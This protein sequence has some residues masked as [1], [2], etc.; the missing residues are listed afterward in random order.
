[1]QHT[2]SSVGPSFL[3]LLALLA[4]A[5]PSRAAAPPAG[6]AWLDRQVA[7]LGADDFDER[8]GAS[9]TLQRA[10]SAAVPALKRGSKGGDPEVRA[11]CLPLL[12]AAEKRAA[13]FFEGLGAAVEWNNAS[14]RVVTVSYSQ[15][16]AGKLRDEHLRELVGLP[17]LDRVFLKDAP[18]G[19]AG[20]R[21]L[22]RLTALDYLELDGTSVTDAG[23]AHL[24][25]LTNLESL[26]LERTKVT[27][28]GLVHLKDMNK[29]LGVS[30]SD[31]KVTDAG[32]AAGVKGIEGRKGPLGLD[33]TG[34][35]VTDDGLA[36]LARIPFPLHLTL[37]RTKVT[38]RGIARLGAVPDLRSLH[39]RDTAVTDKGCVTMVKFRALEDLN[40]SRTAVTDKGCAELAKVK[41]L[42]RVIVAETTVTVVGLRKLAG[43]PKL[44]T[45]VARGN[46][47]IPLE[48]IRELQRL[49]PKGAALEVEQSRPDLEG[50]NDRRRRPD[51]RE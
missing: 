15:R 46:P 8:Q 47:G 26:S 42:E 51:E 34:T 39:L 14:G 3:T 17:W 50:R 37:S 24:A 32:L 19:D 35:L 23:L 2:L 36:C 13:A 25:G 1:M 30:V 31:T 44:K 12:L 10:G 9:R 22:G 29:L 38:D 40:L 20:M 18:V 33:L 7:R 5:A 43:L 28:S 48:Q 6:E 41:S 27:G 11:R 21:H 4:C 16:D 45:L 49:L